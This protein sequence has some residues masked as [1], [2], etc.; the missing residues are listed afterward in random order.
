MKKIGQFIYPWGNGHYSRMMRLDE[1]LPKYLKAEYETYYFSKGEIYNKLL[2]KFPDKKNNIHEILMPTPI[3][4]KYGPSVSL[5]I[6]NMFFPVG[7]NQSLVNQVKNYL[8]KEVSTNH[9]NTRASSLKSH[10][11]FWWPKS[12][13]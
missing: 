10:K 9:D 2:K 3:D 8:K 11:R 12:R 4:G 6:L 13:R 1:K 5:S 7:S